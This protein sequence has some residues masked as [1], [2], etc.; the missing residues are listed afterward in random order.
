MADRIFGERNEKATIFSAETRSER[1][2]FLVLWDDGRPIAIAV[3]SASSLRTRSGPE[4]L[5]L[6][7]PES[8][9]ANQGQFAA[10]AA[11]IEAKLPDLESLPKQELS[12]A[13]YTL[14]G[15]FANG[16]TDLLEERIV[17]NTVV[18]HLAN[19]LKEAASDVSLTAPAFLVLQAPARGVIRALYL[20]QMGLIQAP[21][22]RLSETSSL[23]HELVHAY[24]DR[25]PLP[26]RALLGSASEYFERAHPRLYG[27]VVGD[28][29]EALGPEGRAEETLAFL[30][31]ALA[32]RQIKTVA[33]LQ[34]LQ[35]Q[36][37]LSI[38]EPIL[39]S[40]ILLLIEIGLLPACMAPQETQPSDAEIRFE[41]YEAA[42]LACGSGFE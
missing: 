27:Q 17:A 39:N 11:A 20:P 24:I 5:F 30:A 21:V 23:A 9:S 13:E 31:G 2:R 4:G 34:L 42:S 40:D 19:G 12:S 14:F 16:R 6:A 15:P 7:L 38:S 22:W 8:S 37:L 33:S 10:L 41:Y 18:D 26:R 32:S 35:S 28:L 25:V 36:G 1:F 3:E 29:Y